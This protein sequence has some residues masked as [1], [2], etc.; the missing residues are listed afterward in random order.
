MTIE[1]AVVFGLIALATVLFALETV[2]FD[3]TAV[4]VLSV[5][6]ISGIL[7]PEEG[8]SG[9]SN[10]ATVT[11]GAMFILSEGLRR[12][13]V[14][15]WIGDQFV[16][17]GKN[18]YRTAVVSMM[19]FIS[20]TS[21]FINNT[22]AVAI[23]IPIVL[24]MSST[25]GVSASRLLMPLSFASMFGG[26]STLIGTS[27]NIL[28]SSLAEDYGQEAFGMF[29]FTALGLIML[30]AGFAYLF[31]VGIRLIPDRRSEGD[32]T[33]SYELKEYLTDVVLEP[34][35][36]HLG[37]KFDPDVV[38]QN[39]DLA[40]LHIFKE[41]EKEPTYPYH[42]TME[43]GDVL[44][45]RGSADEIQ[46]LLHR[47]DISLVPTEDWF[48][49]DLQ[50][51]HHA[52]VEAVIAPDSSLEG[53]PIRRIRFGERFGAVVL[54]IRRHGELR[55][56]HLGDVRLSGGDSVLLLMDEDRRHEVDRHRAF[57]LASA[58][59]TVRYRRSRTPI[60]LAIL[61][62]I[63]LTAAFRVVPISVAATVGG[64]MLVLTGCLTTEEAYSAV[65]WKIIF[66]LAGVIPLGI[67]ME[68]TGAADLISEV[69]FTWLGQYGPTA[70][71]SG[72]FFLSMMLTNVI[73][74]QATAVLLA[75]IAFESAGMLDVDP[76]PFLVAV[77]FAA[78][79][80]LMTPVGYQTNTLIY[81]PGQYR[82][83][84]FTRVGAPLNALFWIL[85]TFLI[86][87]FWPF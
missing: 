61:A 44:R 26:V 47:E 57:V 68:K 10:S 78:S 2:S 3:V 15:A 42:T 27:T 71:L 40:V 56:E 18:D 6:M 11:I 59:E 54:A 63:V 17:I 28:V 21:M 67:A 86:P 76:R 81:G 82:F 58:V 51:G 37:E 50:I 34:D 22:A 55:Q 33:E 19:V 8:F 4:I 30:V 16:S 43:A 9:F 70:V 85:A 32:L 49:G 23:F 84:D 41:G 1:I 73:S 35:F 20:V 83:S 79:L 38:T 66:L 48:A 12:T 77:T 87:V 46:K 62:A 24:S 39:L 25:L 65:N 36:A 7:T 53:K 64:L 80:S 29:E 60:A 13:G 45:I 52:L 72:F 74:N 75:P 31:G 14:L 5:L 69:V